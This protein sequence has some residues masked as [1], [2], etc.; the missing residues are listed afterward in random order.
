MPD[1]STIVDC[2]SAKGPKSLYSCII[3][4]IQFET[5]RLPNTSFESF[6]I[7]SLISF[8]C[9]VVRTMT[10]FDENVICL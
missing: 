10:F 6:G 3:S 1:F 9:A 7:I 4:K 2:P 5:T 8:A